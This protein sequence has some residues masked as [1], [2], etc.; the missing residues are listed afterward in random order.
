M[1]TQCSSGDEQNVTIRFQSGKELLY[2]FRII[3]LIMIGES[4]LEPLGLRSVLCIGKTLEISTG[5]GSY[6]LRERIQ[7]I[8]SRPNNLA[9]SMTLDGITIASGQDDQ[10]MQK[11]HWHACG[12]I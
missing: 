9:P 10:S 12:D 5:F 11:L 1:C 4:I 8:L 3:L 2:R 7:N 6:P